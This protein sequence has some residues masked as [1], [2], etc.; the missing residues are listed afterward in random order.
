MTNPAFCHLCKIKGRELDDLTRNN[1]QAHVWKHPRHAD[2]TEVIRPTTVKE[3]VRE[4]ITTADVMVERDRYRAALLHIR[5]R[6][7]FTGYGA[8]MKPVMDIVERALTD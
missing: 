3:M 1:R 6:M 8:E 5:D 4:A 2:T 7:K